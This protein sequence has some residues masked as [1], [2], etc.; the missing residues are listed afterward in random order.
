[1]KYLCL[2][3]LDE[4]S[5]QAQPEHMQEIFMAEVLAFREELQQRGF[6][7]AGAPLQ[8]TAAAVTVRVRY[9]L[10]DISDGP[11]VQATEQLGEFYLIEARDLND[12]IRVASAMPVARFGAVEIRAL[13]DVGLLERFAATARAEEALPQTQAASAENC[14][15]SGEEAT[16]TAQKPGS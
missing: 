4:T 6:C 16:N 14:W 5:V 15:D 10:P 13:A 9:G 3:Y 7:I 12:A 8:S 1:M 11:A 2:V